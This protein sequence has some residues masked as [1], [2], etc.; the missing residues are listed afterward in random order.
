M[1]GKL[2]S[3]GDEEVL[4]TVHG[5]ICG[6][7]RDVSISSLRVAAGSPEDGCTAQINTENKKSRGKRTRSKKKKKGLA[8]FSQIIIYACCWFETL[9][10]AW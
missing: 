9:G 1:L 8:I 7:C 6:R 4:H 3:M 2:V 5:H 10:N